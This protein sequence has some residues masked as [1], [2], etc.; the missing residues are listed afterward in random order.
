LLVIRHGQTEYNVKGLVQGQKDIPLNANGR[1]QAR[2]LANQLQ[3]YHIVKIFASPLVRAKATAEI[4]Q[5]V[6][7]LYRKVPFIVDPALMERDFKPFEGKALKDLSENELAFLRHLDETEIEGVEPLPE[8]TSRVLGFFER[9]RHVEAP[10]LQLDDCVLVVTHMGVLRLVF[11]SI[12][13]VSVKNR[14]S[15]CMVNEIIVDQDEFRLV[16]ND[17]D[18][19]W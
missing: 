9:I 2:T 6:L 8:F 18:V 14:S 3:P 16:E 4:I 1:D 7:G 13:N 19:S 15:N 12:L 11:S 10:G 5:D 17:E